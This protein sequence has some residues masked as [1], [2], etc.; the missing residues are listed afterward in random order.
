[1]E[2]FHHQKE[3]LK[4]L[5]VIEKLSWRRREEKNTLESI[6]C[7]KASFFYSMDGK[8]QTP[9]TSSRFDK[10]AGGKLNTL[11]LFLIFRRLRAKA[12]VIE[13]FVI[14]TVCIREASSFLNDAL[15][16]W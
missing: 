14:K 11:S 8:D 4:V 9:E 6:L 16:A 7:G 13:M 15:T 2:F 3:P 5:N 12:V 1:M 10:G